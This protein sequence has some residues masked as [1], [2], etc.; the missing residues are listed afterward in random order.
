MHWYANYL[1]LDDSGLINELKKACQV[2][3]NVYLEIKKQSPNPMKVSSLKPF[4][5]VHY[6]YVN[7]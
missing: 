5:L 3:F 1:K 2:Q 4:A 6:L 7:L